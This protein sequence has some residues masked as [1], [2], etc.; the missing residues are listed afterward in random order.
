MLNA[1]Q[2]LNQLKTVLPKTRLRI[3]NVCGG[4]ERA[5]SKAGLRTLLNQNIELIPGPGCPV[6]ICPEE[7]IALA[8]KLSFEEDVILL[9]FGDMLRVPIYTDDSLAN[10][11]QAAR[12]LGADIRPIASPNEVIKVAIENPNKKVVFFAVGFETTMAPISAMLAQPLPT[13]LSVLLSGRLTSPAVSF[14]LKDNAHS[15]DALIAPGH[16]AAIMG[17]NEWRF[18]AN[19]YNLPIAI[20]GFHPESL[21]LSIHSILTQHSLGKHCLNNCY[22][23]VVNTIGNSHAQKCLWSMMSVVDANWRGIGVIPNS[24]LKFLP[25]MQ[26]LDVSSHFELHAGVLEKACSSIPADAQC[27][28]VVM[29]KKIPTDCAL[30]G[31]SCTPRTAI[32]PCMVSDEGACKIWWSN[33]EVGKHLSS[34]KSVKGERQ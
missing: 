2:V 9:S 22:Q 19:D 33:G 13:N 17:T 26:H 18:V 4:H 10:S 24:G 27:A 29:G 5:I 30:Y 32:G 25:S 34:R 28:D 3:M 16:V 1:E 12:S 21:L 6:C 7:D 31:K 11:L 14:L 8:I 23:E 15:F 20:A